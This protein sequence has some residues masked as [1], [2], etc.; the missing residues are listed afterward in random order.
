MIVKRRPIMP[1]LLALLMVFTVVSSA[2]LARKTGK[3]HPVALQLLSGYQ[4]TALG[5]AGWA[6]V[7]GREQGDAL[8]VTRSDGKASA[9]YMIMG[10]TSQM[11]QFNNAYSTPGNALVTNLSGVVRSGVSLGAQRQSYGYSIVSWR[12]SNARGLTLYRLFPLPGDP[13]GFIL[14]MR[15]GLTAP[16]EWKRSFR[17]A[18]GVA[19][20]VRCTVHLVARSGSGSTRSRAR[21]ESDEASSYNKEL[22]M[23]YAHSESTGQNYWVSPS[24]D[25]TQ[26]GP[27]GPGYYSNGQKLLPGRSD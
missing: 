26:N 14:A 4:C 13:G 24:T 17:Q 22:G 9:S 11:R 27:A 21:D 5:P 16:S 18:V 25:Y 12:S 8:D 1:A 15:S 6:I 19:T 7:S 20:S 3:A 2:G 10:V 23:E